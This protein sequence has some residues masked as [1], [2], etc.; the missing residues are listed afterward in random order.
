MVIHAVTAVPL[1][2]VPLAVQDVQDVQ[3]GGTEE[4]EEW[5]DFNCEKHTDTGQD[6]ELVATVLQAEASATGP[7][8]AAEC[9]LRMLLRG[10]SSRISCS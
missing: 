4:D 10:C 6:T 2:G 8:L 1:F 9:A 5:T 7:A 3:E